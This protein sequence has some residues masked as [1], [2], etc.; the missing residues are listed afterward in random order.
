[1]DAKTGATCGIEAGINFVISGLL[2]ALVAWLLYRGALFVP[3]G[4]W[5]LFIDTTITCF[6]VCLCTAYFSTKSAM[7]YKRQGVALTA[8]GAWKSALES[9]PSA[10]FPIG[11]CLFGMC[12]PALLAVFGAVF[13]LAGLEA[14]AP[15]QFIVFK[16][17]WGGLFGALVCFAVLSKHL[18]AGEGN[19]D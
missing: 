11:C 14:L 19:N 6:L 1:M 12:L 17:L 18:A 10:W 4:F 8:R 2:N 16:G 13:G 7:R 5:N 9:L 3:F 15:V